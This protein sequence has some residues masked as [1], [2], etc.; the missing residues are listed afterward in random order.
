MQDCLACSGCITS[1]EG[2]LISQQSHEEFL[3]F[4]NENQTRKAI[5]SNSDL[6][7]IVVVTISQQPVLSLAQRY[8]L[9]I[10]LTAAHLS[11][12]LRNLGADYVLNTKISDDLAL[13]ECREQFI[14][15][16]RNN[17]KENPLPMLTS[18]CPGWICYAE[19]THGS[20]IL[21]YVTTTRSPQQI[22]GVLVK[23]WL[24][25]KLQVTPNKIYH[26][27]IMPCYDKKLEASR[28]DFF[29]EIANSKDVDCVITTSVYCLLIVI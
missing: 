5:Q 16:Y 23:Q 14:Q 19:K 9:T 4:L 12:Y 7:Q 18:A 1:A 22:M 17:S 11:G 3:N 20:F 6:V 25:N 21:P 26:A 8:N 10:E 28:E 27:T 29:N 24:A 13:L 15:R 2:V